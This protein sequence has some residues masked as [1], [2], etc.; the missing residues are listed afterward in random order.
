MF[1][2]KIENRFSKVSNATKGFSAKLLSLVP[3]VTSHGSLS[4]IVRFTALKTRFVALVTKRCEKKWTV[5]TGCKLNLVGHGEL[6]YGGGVNGLCTTHIHSRRV[7][8]LGIRRGRGNKAV[9]RTFREGMECFK[10]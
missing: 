7:L 4:L 1:F 3:W 10:S 9:R 8:N 6:H 5:D 2:K